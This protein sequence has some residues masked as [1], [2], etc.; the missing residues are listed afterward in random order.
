MD[1]QFEKYLREGGMQ[2]KYNKA[3][4]L[5]QKEVYNDWLKLKNQQPTSGK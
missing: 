5:E 3:K 4:V 1:P 2:E